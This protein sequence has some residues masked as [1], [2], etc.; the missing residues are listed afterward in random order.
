IALDTAPGQGTSIKLCLP[1][2]E[3][4]PEADQASTAPKD[5][6]AASGETVL[7][8]EDEPV[9]RGVIIEMLHDQGYLTREAADGA[10]GLRILQLDKPVDLLLTDI[11]LPGMNGRQLADQA[12]ELRPHLKI[13]FMTGYAENAANAEGFLQPGMDMITKPFDLGHLSQRVRDIISG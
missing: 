4:I 6:I 7:V 13:L 2:H 3:D 9:V 10:A 8:V 12:R 5:S 11:G 1:R